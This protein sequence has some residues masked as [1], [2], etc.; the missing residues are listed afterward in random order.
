[1]NSTMQAGTSIAHSG[2]N[3]PRKPNNQPTPISNPTTQKTKQ[4]RPIKN[5]QPAKL[6]CVTDLPPLMRSPLL[7]TKNP[8]RPP[9]KIALPT[10]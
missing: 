8:T 7:N 4:K 1:M 3:R 10:L 9:Q 6:P 5:N 2:N